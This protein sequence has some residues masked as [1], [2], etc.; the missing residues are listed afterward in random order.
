MG[1]AAWSPETAS[2]YTSQGG[3]CSKERRGLA[4]GVLQLH[5]VALTNDSAVL[6][7]ELYHFR[8]KS[9]LPVSEEPSRSPWRE[10]LSWVSLVHRGPFSDFP[11]PRT[12]T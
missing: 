3:L 4:P 11:F 1:L 12:V 5:T 8:G 2:L 7:K 6:P 9:R 10:V